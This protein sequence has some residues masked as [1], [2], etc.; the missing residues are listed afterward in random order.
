MVRPASLHTTSSLLTTVR[1]ARCSLR[2]CALSHARVVP[3]LAFAASLG[4]VAVGACGGPTEAQRLR[5]TGVHVEPPPPRVD[6]GSPDDIETDFLPRRHEEGTR[7]RRVDETTIDVAGRTTTVR[8]EREVTVERVEPDGTASLVER[9]TGYERSEGSGRPRPSPSER[10]LDQ[11]TIRYGVTPMGDPAGATEVLG[12]SRTNDALA[13]KLARMVLDHDVLDRREPLRVGGQRRAEG[14]M[15]QEIGGAE[16]TLRWN[17]TFKLVERT[18]SE[19]TLE[20]DA[21]VDL[22]PLT[23]GRQRMRG[24]GNATGRWVIDASDGYA[25]SREVELRL[26]AQPIDENGRA[27]GPTQTWVCRWVTRITRVR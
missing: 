4:G 5:M 9:I 10:G 27:A 26:Y 15:V 13:R 16:A 7:Y 12:T 25:G 24:N 2:S 23:L 3:A 21:T 22:V 11:V 14:Q 17:Y 19:A 1:A 6:A 8:V 20:I 18:D